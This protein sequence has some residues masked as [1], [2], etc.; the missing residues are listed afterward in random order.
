MR[1]AIYTAILNQMLVNEILKIS[2]IVKLGFWPGGDR[3]GNPFVTADITNAVAD[4]LRINL[5]KCYYNDLK[6]LQ[7][8]LT[9][10][11]LQQPH[12]TQLRDSLYTAMFNPNKTVDFEDIIGP[13]RTIR[14]LLI[15]KYHGLYLKDLEHF[16]DKVKIFKTHFAT[17]DIR[18]DHS[19]HYLAVETILKKNDI[20][21]ES[22]DELTETE[23]EDIL[24]HK[25]LKVSAEDFDEEIVKDTLNNISQLKDI[26][27]RNGEEGCNRYIIS[28]SEDI[29]SMLFVYGL[30]RWSGWKTD[31]ITFD[32]VPLFETM[33]GMN[34]AEATMQHLF[35]I[36]EYRAHL[37]RRNDKQTIMLGFSDG[38]K[39]WR[40]F[41]SQ[42]VNFKKLKK[43]SHRFVIIVVSKRYFLMAVVVRQLVVVEKRTVF[44]CCSNQRGS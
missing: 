32:I 19:Q 33:N 5:M 7:Q 42:L 15:D 10:K 14:T 1:L 34:D 6:G 43:C 12:I 31:E 27:K 8:K 24:L 9:F 17:L 35:D 37:R 22:L 40:I 21:S 30:F 25:N 2:H 16:M 26:Q 4:E 44:L 38:T 18:Q 36:P 13:L 29:F 11:A 3:D 23:L 28:N 41:K 39:R 20:I